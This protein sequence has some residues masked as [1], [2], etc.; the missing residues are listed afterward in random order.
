M[1]SQII[2]EFTSDKK[3]VEKKFL[4]NFGILPDLENPQRYNEH[5]SKILLKPP[6]QLTIQCADKYEVRQYV[7]G[8]VGEHILNDLY[9]VYSSIKEL[10]K[11]WQNLPRQF[12]LKA[13]HGCQWNYICKD[14]FQTDFKKIKTLF[15]HWMKSSFYYANRE[16]IYKYLNP[17]IV[18]E[19]YL[20]DL[21]GDL[22][23]YKFY[24]FNGKVKYIHVDIDRFK[25]HSRCFYDLNWVKQ[26]FTLRF[27]LYEGEVKKPKNLDEMIK[28]AEKLSENFPH[29]RVD[30]Y[31]INGKIF[32]GELTFTPGNGS[33]RFLPDKY[34]F[35]FGSFF[36]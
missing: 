2:G 35:Y 24:C 4:K 34:D 18:A 26:D 13:T 31:N 36:E 27:P 3:Y 30:L 25:R 5:I 22:L 28:V 6:D 15:N 10:G 21:N 19:E 14:K 23:D 32:F 9:G 1:R 8:K 16:L 12:V 29:V 7:K 20:E 33:E 11:D 17:K